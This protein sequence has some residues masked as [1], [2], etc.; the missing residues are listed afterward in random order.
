MLN[1]MCLNKTYTKVCIGKSMPDAF[2]I[3]NGMKQADSPSQLL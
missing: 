3:Q 2:P 1:E